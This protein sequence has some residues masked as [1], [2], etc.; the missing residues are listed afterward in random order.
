MPSTVPVDTSRIGRAAAAGEPR[1][2]APAP[3]PIVER[4]LFS[5]PLD[6]RRWWTIV[7]EIVA[8]TCTGAIPLLVGANVIARYT[9]L[10]RILWAEDVVKML[11]LWVVFLGGA[12]AAKY[13]AH[14]RMGLLSDRVLGEGHAAAVWARVI[15]LSPVVV[16]G[17]L[18]V[19]GV[20]IV[21]IS[22]RRELPSLQIPAGYFTTI[23]PASGGLM[24]LYALHGAWAKRGPEA[25]PRE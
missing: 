8:L 11:F 12:L 7:P 6:R 9:N 1:P 13:D 18:L 20:P 16:G 17:L 14:V 15:R 21:Q 4:D 10:F 2:P 23:I 22:M 25:H 5:I 3:E 24:I 19:L